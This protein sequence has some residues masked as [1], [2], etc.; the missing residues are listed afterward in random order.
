[1]P[2]LGNPRHEAFA[3]ELAKGK[4]ATEAYEIAGFKPD[5]KNAH[6]LTTNDGVLT[7]VA[8]LQ[9]RAACRA[10]VTVENLIAEAEAARAA[11]MEKGQLSAAI[12]AIRRTG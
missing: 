10:V 5:R 11:A 2:I 12:S 4:S 3:R 7:R 8:E 6:R 9:S 1:M